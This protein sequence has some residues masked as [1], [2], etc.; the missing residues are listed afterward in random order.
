LQSHWNPKPARGLRGGVL[1]AL[2]ACA[3]VAGAEEPKPSPAPPVELEKLYK[4]PS[5]APAAEAPSPE[6][7]GSA[8]K[9]EWRTRFTSARAERD[10]A[11]TALETAQ[12]K[13]GE[14]AGEAE[15][16]QMAPPGA[17]T[18]GAADAPVSY[19]LRQEVRRQREEVTR[20]ERRLRD[21]TIEADLAG[22]PA[23]WRE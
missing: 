13:L 3:G 5:A 2:L 8:S 17:S 1:A 15:A 11:Q 9:E 6:R 18:S 19:A 20:S 4:L 22:V 10:A 21:L 16:W 23:D 7:V 12:K 14:A